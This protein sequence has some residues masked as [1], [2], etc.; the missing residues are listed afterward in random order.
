MN[1]LLQIWRERHKIWEGLMGR[2]FKKPSVEAIADARMMTC[3]H[4]P[5]YDPF[6][7]KCMLP[8]TQPCCAECGCS[9]ELK[10]RSM[11]SSCPRG[12]WKAEQE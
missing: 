12:Y 9:L 7:L 6:G 1:K 5:K 10:T 2:L 4:C 3:M 11:S 8:G